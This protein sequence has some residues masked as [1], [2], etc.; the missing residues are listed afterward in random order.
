MRKTREIAA[1]NIV[2]NQRLSAST[3]M[4]VIV[5][6]D[7]QRGEGIQ[8]IEQSGLKNRYV[9]SEIKREVMTLLKNIP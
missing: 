9:A 3:V 5:M 7:N 6:L 8:T 4:H 1:V 2:V